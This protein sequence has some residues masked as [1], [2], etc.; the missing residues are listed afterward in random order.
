MT[1][2]QHLALRE[3]FNFAC[4]YCGISETDAGARLT[5]DHFRP[6]AR[7]GSDEEENWVYACH[8]CN[9]FKGAYWPQEEELAL[10]QPG[11]DE[12][13]VHWRVDENGVLVA[14]TARGANHI[15]KVQLNRPALVAN[16]AQKLAGARRDRHIESLIE[17]LEQIK[18]ETAVLRARLGS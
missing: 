2:A 10:L 18:R 1:R 4:G 3:R 14:L 11:R 7:G 12:V 8:A 17:E 15:E 16:R 5:V 13:S 9:E 6:V